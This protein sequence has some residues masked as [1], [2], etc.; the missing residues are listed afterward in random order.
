[1]DKV[2]LLVDNLAA[3]DLIK[4]PSRSLR[5]IAKNDPAMGRLSC[6]LANVEPVCIAH[7]NRYGVFLPLFPRQ[8]AR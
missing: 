7:E 8:R 3:T 2:I 1:M 6:W 4:R 5:E